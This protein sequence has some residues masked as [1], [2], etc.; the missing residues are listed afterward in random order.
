MNTK[1]L[2]HRQIT[3]DAYYT[4]DGAYYILPSGYPK[5]VLLVH[6]S[7]ADCDVDL[8]N[9]EEARARFSLGDDDD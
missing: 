8:I 3:V 5:K 6:E 4:D 7:P 9:A 2:T 1:D